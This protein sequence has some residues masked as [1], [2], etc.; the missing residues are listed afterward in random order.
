MENRKINILQIVNGFNIG[1]AELKLLELIRLLDKDKYNIAV[2]SVGGGGPLQKE[3]ERL[4]LNVFV[5]KKHHRFDL[6]L[7]V[8][9]INVMRNLRIDIVQTTLFYADVIG[10][11][12][13]YLANVPIVISW[14]VGEHIHRP[15]RLMAYRLASRKI[16]NVVAVSRAIQKQIIEE[17]WI[18]PENVIMIHYGIDVDRYVNTHMLK[19]EDIGLRNEHIVLGTVARLGEQKGHK[20]LISA[21]PQIVRQFPNVHF[22]FAGDGPL[23]HQLENQIRRLDLEDHFH[24]LGFRSDVVNLLH[25]FDVFVLPSLYEGLPNAVLEA[26]ACNKPVIATGVDGTSEAVVDQVTGYI[27]PSKHPEALAQKIIQLLSTEGQIQA[28]GKSGGERIREHFSI[29]KQVREFENL[30]DDLFKNQKITG[31][32]ET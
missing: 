1:G 14:E 2:C 18:H 3:F 25:L 24:L 29:E 12:A 15:M 13:A 10:A 7:L 21:A 4:G 27:V 23:R 30:Y 31:E 26:M 32:Y 5:F 11:Y 28:M 8:K 19:R 6:S 22:V 20:Y 9:T 17:K 16:D